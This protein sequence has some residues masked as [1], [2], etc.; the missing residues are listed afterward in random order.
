MQH[1]L[2]RIRK[3]SKQATCQPIVRLSILSRACKSEKEK[4]PKRPLITNWY[5]S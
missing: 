4:T 1:A 2:K 5:L 3:H